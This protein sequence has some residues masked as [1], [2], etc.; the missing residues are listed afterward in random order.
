MTAPVST[1]EVSTLATVRQAYRSNQGGDTFV[2]LGSGCTLAVISKTGGVTYVNSA[3]ATSIT[4]LGGELNIMAG[5]HAL[6][7]TEAGICYYRSTGTGPGRFAATGY[8]YGNAGLAYERHGWRV[9]VGYFLAES[10]ARELFPYPVA[11]HKLAGTL[12]WHF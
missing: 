8:A 12:S 10:Q 6:I 9:D 4:Q 2:T 5:T 7:T 1:G 3:T 11:N